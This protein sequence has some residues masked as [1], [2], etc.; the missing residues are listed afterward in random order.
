MFDTILVPIRREGW[1]FIAGF[2]VLALVLAFV[3]PALGWLGG[4]LAAW[5]V[6]FFRDPPRVVPTG[7]GVL[8]SPADG[9]IMPIVETSPPPE[10]DMGETP[11]PRISI[12][13]NVFDVHVNR[14]PADGEV[15]GLAYRPGR[16]VNASLDKASEGN[17]RQ[18]VRMTTIDGKDVAIVQIAGLIARRIVC[19][20]TPGQAVS[21][22]ERFGMIRF[23][24]RVDVY[25][26]DG[27]TPAVV[28]GQRSIAGETII[29]R[30]QAPGENA[31]PPIGVVR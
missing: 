3:A 29:A 16:F 8:V 1:P 9:R 5:C 18:S 13:M 19:Y 2:V 25:L 27:M 14:M 24:S 15:T 12:F 4:L 28:D 26:D 31:A 23:G 30:N 20:L 17:E 6:F 10:L 21:V 7:H 11:R 22:G